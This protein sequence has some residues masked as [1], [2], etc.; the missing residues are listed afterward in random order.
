MGESF[1]FKTVW[2]FLQLT[3][4]AQSWQPRLSSEGGL[5]G[6]WISLLVN[7]VIWQQSLDYY[8]ARPAYYSHICRLLHLACFCNLFINSLTSHISADSPSADD[9]AAD[10]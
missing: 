10:G 3:L 2:L 6:G 4:P 8:C 9:V 7:L 1:A 5:R